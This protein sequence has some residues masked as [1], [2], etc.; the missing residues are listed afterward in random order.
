MS[1]FDRVEN[2]LL[3]WIDQI[4][5]RLPRAIPDVSRLA[6]C[7]MVSH[8]GEHDGRRVLENTLAAF[9]AAAAQGVWGIECDIR[10]TRDLAPVVTH[11]A[12]LRRVFGLNR[13]VATCTLDELKRDC[14]GLPALAEVI[15]RYGG[16]T[17][18]MVEVKRE[19]YPHPERQNRVLRD[20]FAGLTPGTDFHLLS[21][22]PEMFRLT[23]FAPPSACIP[24]ARL[25]VPRMSRLAQR[26]GYG[27]VAGHYAL[28]GNAVIRRQHA[29]GQ[30][31]GTGYP[32]SL[33]ALAREVNRQV[34]WIFTN[35][36]GVLQGWI[37]RLQRRGG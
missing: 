1:F 33:R 18:L 20:L 29:A 28:V 24:V 37:H 22:T 3:H 26:N 9:D 6:G 23:P 21:L 13:A 25:N 30:G 15:G 35:H 19:A 14:P 17:H 16:Q 8:R 34:D 2:R 31:V 7:R 11:D 36:V 12:D 27:G 4:F 32:R 10:W 5:E